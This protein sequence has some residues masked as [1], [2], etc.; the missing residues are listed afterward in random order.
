MPGVI[1]ATRRLTVAQVIEDLV[2]LA[3]CSCE[4]EWEGRVL[5]LPL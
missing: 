1:V 5:Y 3:E 4:S 2:L